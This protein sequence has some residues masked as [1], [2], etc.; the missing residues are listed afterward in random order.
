MCFVSKLRYADSCRNTATSVLFSAVF[1]LL[2]LL[3]LASL[4]SPQHHFFLWW[5]RRMHSV[6]LLSSSAACGACGQSLY[7]ASWKMCVLLKWSAEKHVLVQLLQPPLLCCS[8]ELKCQI[9]NTPWVS[10]SSAKETLPAAVIHWTP[11][12]TEDGSVCFLC[13]LGFVARSGDSIWPSAKDH[14]GTQR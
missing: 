7:A 4:L 8:Q 1:S 12:S 14:L 5:N 2:S 11:K 3:F 13:C 6:T 9:S 10:I